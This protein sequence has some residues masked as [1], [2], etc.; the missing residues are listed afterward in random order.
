MSVNPDNPFVPAAASVSI[1]QASVATI[2][3]ITGLSVLTVGLYQSPAVQNDGDVNVLIAAIVGPVLGGAL[4]ILLLLA[5]L[6]IVIV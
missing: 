4:I 1:V 3:S 5:I 6:I 2:Q